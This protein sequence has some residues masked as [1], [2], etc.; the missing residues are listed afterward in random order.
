VAYVGGWRGHANL[1]DEA[2]FV[3]MQGLFER[4][5]L[6]PFDGGTTSRWQ[7]LATRSLRHGLLAGGTLINRIPAWLEMAEK[8]YGMGKRLT[9]FGTG[10]ANPSFW[11]RRYGWTDQMDR[12]R[13]VLSKCDFIG[14]RGPISATLLR[15]VGVENVEVV[16]DPVIALAERHP[17][18][19]RESGCLGMNIGYSSGQLWGEN[20]T[21]LC[22]EY[23]KLAKAATR[24]GYRVEWFVVWPDDLSV[25]RLAA[26]RSGTAELIHE[27]YEDPTEFL[28]TVRRMRFFVG[29][30]LHATL[31]ATCA[32]VPSV[33]V[34]YRPKCRDYMASIAQEEATVRTDQFRAE[35]IWEMLSAWETRREEL[36]TTLWRHISDLKLRQ[37]VAA[38]HVADSV[39]AIDGRNE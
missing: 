19:I 22:E 2:L 38:R 32:Y 31:L 7:V 25:T 9:V 4:F 21:R 13:M 26:V 8:F 29:M 5:M 39:F 23:V 36:A 17:A 16:G 15:N 28:N 27:I 11:D 6:V 33:M 24:K 3:A 34:E 37:S 12:W 10:V 20:E 14:V 30:K 18:R 1:G 35:L